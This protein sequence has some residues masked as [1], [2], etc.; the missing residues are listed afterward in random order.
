MNK[1]VNGYA[2]QY[3]AKKP[4]KIFVDG[5]RI[6]EYKGWPQ[7]EV[8]P[9]ETS[10]VIGEPLVE[11]GDI[12]QIP[13][14]DL[15][16]MGL[17]I[18]HEYVYAY[19]RWYP[20]QKVKHYITN[21]RQG[22]RD[23][24]A[25]PISKK[26][27]TI[28]YEP[29]NKVIRLVGRTA[30][31]KGF[32]PWLYVEDKSKKTS[33]LSLKD[34]L[35]MSKA[36]G[37]IQKAYS[38]IL[39]ISEAV[40]EAQIPEIP[41]AITD[42]GHVVCLPDDEPPKIGFIGQT[43]SGKTLA[44]HSLVDCIH[45]KK[46]DRIFITNDRQ[47][48]MLSWARPSPTK[49]FLKENNKINHLANP[50]PM[51]W[52]FPN[53][54]ELRHVDHYKEN[55]SFKIS[56]PFKDCV[57]DFKKF[58]VGRKA[59]ELGASEKHF[60]RIKE[61]VMNCTTMDQIDDLLD[62]LKKGKVIPSGTDNKISNVLDD[63]FDQR[64]LDVNTEV[65]STWSIRLQDSK[66]NLFEKEYNPV[67]ALLNCGLIPCIQTAGIHE[68]DY[69]PQYMRYHIKDVYN[70]VVNGNMLYKERTW[71]IVDEIGQIYKKSKKKTVAAEALIDSFTEGRQI[72]LAVGYTIQSWTQIDDEIRNNTTHVVCF[73]MPN[74]AE[75][76]ELNNTFMPS[77]YYRD[78]LKSS[79]LFEA[80]L[81]TTKKWVCYDE[82]GKR[83]ETSDPVKGKIIF[84]MSEHTKSGG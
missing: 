81:F 64:I 57:Y 80:V 59:W 25:V 10:F 77:Q 43:G 14:S 27:L 47:R 5:E 29:Y 71:L 34:R 44:L 83:Y 31:E 66:G 70:N 17:M 26:E 39:Q 4:F 49:M 35:N 65:P 63:L 72:G 42:R 79:P 1:E 15:L 68:K 38:G 62:Q 60:K 36:L 21:K 7:Y 41:V 37:S 78:A 16:D 23:V 40:E 67:S 84:P 28:E 69:F 75:C 46:K 24:G 48:Q 3:L 6:L 56:L 8:Q 53:N 22:V 30:G 12:K 73:C 58:F 76:A 54:A 45:H 20:T 50:L 52:L 18:G 2:K 32:G 9:V 51:I 33:Q 13:Y 19:N 61:D 74:K 11:Y 82:K 55:V